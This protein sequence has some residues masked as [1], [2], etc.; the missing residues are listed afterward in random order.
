MYDDQAP[1]LRS[2][3]VVLSIIGTALALGPLQP[4]FA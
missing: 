2:V 1:R 4:L 3:L